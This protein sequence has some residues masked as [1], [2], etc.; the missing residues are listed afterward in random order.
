VR[1]G[2]DVADQIHRYVTAKGAAE[3]AALAA[4]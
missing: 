1:D 3:P 4:E 2:R